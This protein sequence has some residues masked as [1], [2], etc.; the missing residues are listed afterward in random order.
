MAMIFAIHTA[1]KQVDNE[2]GNSSIKVSRTPPV[3]VRLTNREQRRAD[4]S[5]ETLIWTEPWHSLLCLRCSSRPLTRSKMN[6]EV[7]QGRRSHSRYP[8]GLPETLRPGSF[9]AL[10]NFV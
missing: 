1:C 4:V 10:D 3:L 8:P 9:E 2:T 6:E 7:R 5:R